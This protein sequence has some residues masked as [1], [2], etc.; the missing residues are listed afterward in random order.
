MRHDADRVA[1]L[2]LVA[3][4][5]DML[6]PGRVERRRRLVEQQNVGLG[7]KCPRH[8]EALLLAA[9]KRERAVPQP[10]FHLVPQGGPA[11]RALDGGIDL[12]AGPATV[13]P[14]PRRDV[15]VDRHR[16]E[17]R[18][19]L[20]HH[21]DAPPQPDRIDARIVDVLAVE[22]H[23]ARDP[24]SLRELVHAVQTTQERRLAAPGR[25]DQRGDCVS[26][27]HERHVFHHGPA[28]VQ[29]REP[30][31]LELEPGVSGRRHDVAESP[32]GR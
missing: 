4:L 25:A 6:R 11:Q 13:H 1:G 10:I 17:W 27:E 14:Q 32:S 28:S 12:G 23:V 29:R 24:A 2:E 22:Q 5:L 26:G 8:A 15:V 31:G 19:P 30:R 7:G 3:Q 18:G 9:R 16:R 21:A 20:E